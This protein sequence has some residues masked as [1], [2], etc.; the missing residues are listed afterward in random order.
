MFHRSLYNP[1]PAWPEERRTKLR[2]I[3]AIWSSM[4]PINRQR[5]IASEFATIA[6]KGRALQ[7][8]LN[9]LQLDPPSII[10]PQ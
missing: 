9:Q 1:D 5:V 8:A 7:L 2:N 3:A 4:W 6:W 10:S